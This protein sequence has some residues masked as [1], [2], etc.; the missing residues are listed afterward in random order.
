M[1]SFVQSFLILQYAI[2][3]LWCAFL[4]IEDDN[5]E[6][7]AFRDSALFGVVLLIASVIPFVNLAVASLYK[8]YLFWRSIP[9]RRVQSV[10]AYD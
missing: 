9:D 6:G 8:A 1:P 7:E 2:G 3:G 10:A 5:V 4:W